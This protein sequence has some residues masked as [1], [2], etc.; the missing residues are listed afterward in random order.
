VRNTGYP[1]Q[2]GGSVSP[3]FGM[4]GGLGI[5]YTLHKKNNFNFS[6][7][8]NS[9]GNNNNGYLDQS[10][11]TSN[12]NGVPVSD[13]FTL[14]ETQSDFRLHEINTPAW[15]IK[16]FQQREP[17]TQYRNTFFFW[18]WHYNSTNNQ[19]AQPGDSCFMVPIIIT[20]EN[21]PKLKS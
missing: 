4:Q 8:S 19:F 1:E 11:S 17:G 12:N 13:V 16:N 9:F 2:D 7:S 21:R 10:Q 18:S 3:G 20:R 6:I 5:D 14:S 15:I